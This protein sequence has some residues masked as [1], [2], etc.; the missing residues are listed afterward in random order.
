LGKLFQWRVGLRWYVLSLGL[1]VGVRLAQG[2]LALL[3]GWV[4]SL[5]LR[6]WS[7][8]QF[9]LIGVFALIGAVM[10]ELG[11]RGY[12]LPRLLAQ[13]PALISALVIGIPWGILHLGLALPGMMNAGTPWTATVLQIIGL[14]VVLTWLFIQARGSLVIVI[15]YHAGQN[16]FVFLNDGLTASQDLWLLTV[17]TLLLALLLVILYGPNLQR[18]PEKKPVV[19]EIKGD[20]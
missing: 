13:R 19:M 4:P 20:A 6:P 2:L 7:P 8:Q 10:E 12:A 17:V 18:E 11:W 9:L 15:L 5:Q 14:S 16:F 3:L 1:A